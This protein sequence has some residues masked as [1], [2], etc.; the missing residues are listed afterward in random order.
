VVVH[1]GLR[2]TRAEVIE[3]CRR[4]L[5]EYKLPR[6]IEFVE[7]IPATLTG[8]TPRSEPPSAD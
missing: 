6:V 1:P 3:Q 5:G 8:K 7:S 2:L 4:M